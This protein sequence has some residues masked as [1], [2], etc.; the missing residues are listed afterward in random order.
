MRHLFLTVIIL[1]FCFLGKAQIKDEAAKKIDSVAQKVIYHLQKQQPDSVYA[2]TAPSFQEKIT[3]ENFNSILKDQLFP[4]NDFKLVTFISY[5][6][7]INKYKVEGTP[8]LQLLVGLDEL[9]KVQT[10]LIQPFAE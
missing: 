7:G 1:C 9:N 5:A 10:L 4:L 3:A 8:T 2:F 6:D